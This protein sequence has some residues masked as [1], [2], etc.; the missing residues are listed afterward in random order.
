MQELV[1]Q[2]QCDRRT[3]VTVWE[4]LLETMDVEDAAE[5]V[6]RSGRLQEQLI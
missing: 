6:Q 1:K 4:D 2:V 5:A 3:V